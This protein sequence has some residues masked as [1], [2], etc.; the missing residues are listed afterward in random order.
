MLKTTTGIGGRQRRGLDRDD[1]ARTSSVTLPM[2]LDLSAPADLRQ[3]R[4]RQLARLRPRHRHRR[5]APSSRSTPAASPASSPRCRWPADRVLLPPVGPRPPRRRRRHHLARADHHLERLPGLV[6]RA[7]T[8]TLTVPTGEHLQT[9]AL[10]EAPATSRSRR[11]SS[12]SASRPSPH[13]AR[14]PTTSSPRAR[15]HRSRPTIDVSVDDAPD[16][17]ADGENSTD[18][19]PDGHGRRPRRRHRRRRRHRHRRRRGRAPT[20]SRR[21]TSS[22]DN[23]TSLF[24][25]VRAAFKGAGSDLT[26]MTG[27]GLDVPIPFVGSSVSQL[28]GAGASGAEG[29][30]YAQ[31][32]A[33]AVPATDAPRG[34]RRPRDDH[35]DGRGQTFTRRSSAARSSSAR[36]PP[37]S[38][39]QGDTPSPSRRSSPPCRSTTPP[40]SCENELLGAVH[41]LQRHDAGHAAGDPRHGPGLARQR[42]DDRLR[43]GRRTTTARSCAST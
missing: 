1:H 36:P 41:V 43:A 21:S 15:R 23:P 39:T 24:G 42:L 16:A 40:T 12:R 22:P 25:G 13:R 37:P 6:D 30:K 17:F 18:A 7:A 26:T 20:C 31:A 28:I 19:H 3:R 38:S 5:R 32:P 10:T 34:R 2:A 27:G 29:V 14:R 33:A 11:S 8:S 4:R 9:L 35:A